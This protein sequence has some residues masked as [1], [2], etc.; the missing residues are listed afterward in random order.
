MET[1]LLYHIWI[2]NKIM[3]FGAR[4]HCGVVQQFHQFAESRGKRI[5]SLQENHL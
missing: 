1:L 3:G 4:I 2:L 5:L